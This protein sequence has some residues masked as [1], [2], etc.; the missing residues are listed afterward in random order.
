MN[1]QSVAS[2]HTFFHQSKLPVK[3][4]QG[5]PQYPY[6]LFLSSEPI[7]KFRSTQPVLKHSLRL[8]LH[9]LLPSV[10]LTVLTRDT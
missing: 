10:W 6:M 2:R 1:I 9:W 5:P 3:S 7:N 4:V 8:L